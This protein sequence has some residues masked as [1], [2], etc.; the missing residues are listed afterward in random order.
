MWDLQPLGSSKLLPSDA[1]YIGPSFLTCAL[2]HGGLVFPHFG[3]LLNPVLQ[4]SYLAGSCFVECLLV[5]HGLRRRP[6]FL[7]I[8]AG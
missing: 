7:Q 2:V 8:H 3:A 4:L 5:R 1:I 6:P